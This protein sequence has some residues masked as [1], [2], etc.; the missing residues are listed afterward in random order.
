MKPLFLF[1][2]PGFEEIEAITTIDVLRRAR[3]NVISVS[4]AGDLYVTGAHGISIVADV[5]YPDADL[6][7]A[8][9]LILP[10]GMPGTNNLNVHEG[11]KKALKSHA[12]AGKP[13]AAICAAPLI[14]GQL[15]LLEGKE[16]TC[17]PGYESHLHGA[18]LSKKPVV[19]DGVIITAN[20]PGAAFKFSLQIV[21][22][23]SDSILAS[24]L[25]KNMML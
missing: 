16:A 7:D 19:Q 9:M 2:A 24:E 5:L 1:L 20:G 13:L 10:G 3:L 11:L 4:L 17:Y 25:S 23:F 6:T 22:Y 14:L 12:E 18:I 15:G 21:Q 8:T